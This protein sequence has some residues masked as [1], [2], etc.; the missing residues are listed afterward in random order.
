MKL[1]GKAWLKFSIEPEGNDRRVIVTAYYDTRS[2]WGFIYWYMFLPFH[3]F[4]FID[5][6]RQINKRS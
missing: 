2:L 1:P 5:L 3:N 4:I 6:L